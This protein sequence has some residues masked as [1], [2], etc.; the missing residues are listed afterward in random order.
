MFQLSK[1]SL[2]IF[3]LNHPFGKFCSSNCCGCVLSIDIKTSGQKYE[4]K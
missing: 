1:N 4:E 2:I 3:F